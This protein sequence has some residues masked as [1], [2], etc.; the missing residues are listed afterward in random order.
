MAD[1]CQPRLAAP[2]HRHWAFISPPVHWPVWPLS[3]ENENLVLRFQTWFLET[4]TIVGLLGCVG[5]IDKL[6]HGPLS[7]ASPVPFLPGV[8]PPS[9]FLL[10]AKIAFFF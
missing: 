2:L 9:I 7:L 4:E 10:K 3:H 6:Q 8:P 5:F 1:L